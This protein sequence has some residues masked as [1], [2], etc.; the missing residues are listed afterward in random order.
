M[1]NI[2]L[3]LLLLSLAA[4]EQGDDSLEG[5]YTIAG[6][7]MLQDTVFNRQSLKGKT[8]DVYLYP[9]NGG[10]YLYHKTA[11]SL[12]NFSLDFLRSDDTYRL[13]V[14]MKGDSLQFHG[15]TSFSVRDFKGARELSQ[16]TVTQS[17]SLVSDSVR[18]SLYPTMAGAQFI[19]LQSV[20]EANEPLAYTEVCF[21]SSHSQYNTKD[22]AQAAFKVTTDGQGKAF[23]K[24]PYPG[25]FYPYAKKILP[26]ADTLVTAEQSFG[27]TA[28]TVLPIT[29]TLKK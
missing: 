26:P 5:R 8:V 6:R 15:D 17:T 25:R 24:V 4:C 21:F 12:G 13:V 18:I 19:R 16:N 20:D 1:K 7:A 9:Q 10:G 3:V 28:G 27:V 23:L 14:D 22:C 29:L 2:L 11:D